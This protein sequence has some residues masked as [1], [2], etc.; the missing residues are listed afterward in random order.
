VHHDVI[1]SKLGT[2]WPA[3]A[4][5]SVAVGGVSVSFAEALEAAN[6]LRASRT[7]A[8][9]P[10]LRAAGSPLWECDYFAV[11]APYMEL[12][13]EQPKTGRAGAAGAA[14]S[15]S[16]SL[17]YP[18]AA[19]HHSFCQAPGPPVIRPGPSPIIPDMLTGRQRA[20]LAELQVPGRA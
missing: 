20:D 10:V 9:L 14:C 5:R 13:R 4:A 3:L 16:T 19:A 8:I 17:I 15:C 18:P 6:I 2:P 11:A 12:A 1:L 7:S